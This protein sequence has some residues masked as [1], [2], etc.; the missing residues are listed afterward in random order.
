MISAEHGA[1]DDRAEDVD[2][3]A[4]V[5][6]PPALAPPTAPKAALASALTAAK[7]KT[8]ARS[9]RTTTPRIVSLIGPSAP[10]SSMSARVTVGESAARTMP[11]VSAT[12]RAVGGVHVGHE[13]EEVREGE[14]GAGEEDDGDD[15]RHAADRKDGAEAR[16]QATEV[17][18]AAGRERDEADGDV[19]D[20]LE[21]A[22]HALGDEVEDA[23]PGDEAAHEI[24]GE[25]RE[26]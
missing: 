4:R 9:A 11:I 1:D 26:A 22:H 23:R 7:A 21:V 20:E 14:D 3:R 17:E 2:R 16:A 12:T 6:T 19:V 13:R 25:A 10:V 24:A 18:L 5:A 8:M 15:E